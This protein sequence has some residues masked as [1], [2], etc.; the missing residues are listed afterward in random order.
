MASASYP[1]TT[2]PCPKRSSET[3]EDAGKAA[4]SAGKLQTCSMMQMTTGARSDGRLHTG[5]TFAERS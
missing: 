3:G 5:S 2:T 1:G 4:A